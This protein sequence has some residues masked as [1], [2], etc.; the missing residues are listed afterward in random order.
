METFVID[1]NIKRNSCVEI[2][3]SRLNVLKQLSGSFYFKNC[4]QNLNISEAESALYEGFFSLEICFFEATLMFPQSGSFFHK[5]IQFIAK[6]FQTD[7]IIASHSIFGQAS[8]ITFFFLSFF[9]FSFFSSPIFVFLLS[10][11]LLNDTIYCELKEKQHCQQ[12]K[13]TE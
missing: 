1:V 3:F 12:M 8:Q 4:F 7:S 9:S 13:K 11:F 2:F 5:R 10:D 6:N